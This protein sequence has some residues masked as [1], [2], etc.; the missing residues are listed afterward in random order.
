MILDQY[1]KPVRKNMLDKELAAPGV[2]GVRSLWNFGQVATG[3]TPA[4]MAR[5][6]RD[7][8]EGGDHEAYLTL[9]EEM[10]ERDAH[11]SSVLGTRKRAV[12]GLPVVVEA[13]TDDSMHVQLADEI[14]ALLARSGTRA[15]MED[16][17]DGLGKGYAV[18]EIIWDRSSLPWVPARYVFRDPRFF[19]FDRLTRSE[20]RM[21]DE[22]DMMNGVALEPYKFIRH[23]PKL[24]SGIPIRGGWPRV[25]AWSWMF[26]H[27]GSRT[28]WPSPRSSACRCASQVQVGRTQANIDILMM[29]VANLASTPPRHPGRHVH[30]IPGA[31]Q[32]HGRSGPVRAPGAV[33]GQ[34]D[35]Q[36]CARP[37]HD[38][39]RRI[40]PAQAEVH[41]EVRTD[42]RDAD[43]GQLAET[44]TRPGHL[45]TS[46]EPW[47]AEGLPARVP[48]EPE[49]AT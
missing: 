6:L 33:H 40:Q 32:H 35:Q 15:M 8:A 25:V 16:C 23:I 39:G 28:G 45:L 14:R 17:L 5:V 48:A 4:G 19:Q 36:G 3:L 1:G 42:L 7:A 46:A 20:I 27:Y 30:R 22:S 37:D 41:D 34:P 29:A 43:A 11:Y 47:P 38:H 2:T 26:K 18:V 24:K 13:A 44:W 49:S 9:A 21:R 31:G 12:S 10:E